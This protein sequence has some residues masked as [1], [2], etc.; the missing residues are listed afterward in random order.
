MALNT[1]SKKYLAT[2]LFLPFL[3]LIIVAVSTSDL[4]SAYRVFSVL[5]SRGLDLSYQDILKAEIISAISP[6]QQEEYSVIWED[7][8][9]NL[10]DQENFACLF[11]DLRMIYSRKPLRKGV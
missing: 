5:N 8:E 1:L 4:D 10:L 6:E 3:Y 11:S 9:S 7:I 2:I